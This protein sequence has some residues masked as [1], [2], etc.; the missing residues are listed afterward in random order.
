MAAAVVVT[1]REHYGNRR[2][3]SGTIT[4]DSTYVN[5]TGEA[6]SASQLKLRSID[7]VV[8]ENQE[9]GYV[10]MYD[11]T[12]SKVVLYFG[13]YAAANGPLIEAANFDA[14]GVVLNFTATGKP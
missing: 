10:P 1:N 4:L 13:N 9:D 3:V 7:Q 11:R 8:F 5:G 2:R 14:S 12:N 6:V